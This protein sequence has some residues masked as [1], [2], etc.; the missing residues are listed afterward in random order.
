MSTR[1]IFGPPPTES[2]SQGH[3]TPLGRAHLAGLQRGL[4]FLA[5]LGVL[6]FLAG[7]S[8]FTLVSS[9]T[10]GNSTATDFP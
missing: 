3:A 4:M 10:D 9:Q 2:S 7:F 8:S 1:G 6:L 5:I